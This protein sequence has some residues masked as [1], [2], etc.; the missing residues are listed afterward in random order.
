LACLLV[1]CQGRWER[2]GPWDKLAF[3]TTIPMA[4]AWKKDLDIAEGGCSGNLT[5][6]V[7]GQ[8]LEGQ[9][10]ADNTHRDI[11]KNILRTE[12]NER[13]AVNK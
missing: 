3:V 10:D 2:C 12:H 9:G 1:R 11:G 7:A 6:R 4:D 5:G 13:A 8:T